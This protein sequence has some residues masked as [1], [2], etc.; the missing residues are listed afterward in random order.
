MKM[1]FV[2]ERDKQKKL[3]RQWFNYITS[4]KARPASKEAHGLYLVG[5]EGREGKCWN[6]IS[7]ST[8]K[9]TVN[10]CNVWLTQ[11]HKNVQNS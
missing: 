6:S 4:G 5:W 1:M 7:P 2:L 3:D 8:L 10:N 9:R 11:L